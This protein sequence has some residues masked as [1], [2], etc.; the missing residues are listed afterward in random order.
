MGISAER[1]TGYFSTS[2]SKRAASAG[3]KIDMVSVPDSLGLMPSTP[4]PTPLQPYPSLPLGAPDL[5]SET[6]DPA[7]LAAPLRSTPASPP[8]RSRASSGPALHRVP[9]QA[10]H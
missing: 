10:T 1:F 3:E 2:T 5:D 8:C 6:W 4:V 7:I 9:G